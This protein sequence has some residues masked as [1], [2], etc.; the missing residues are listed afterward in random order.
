MNK[1]ENELLEVELCFNGEKKMLRGDMNKEE[2]LEILHSVS[3]IEHISIGV[4]RYLS[5]RFAKFLASHDIDV[6]RD[7]I[8]IHCIDGNV[9]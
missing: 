3:D 4:P 7:H 6:I 8:E 5:A 1:N 9:C 2:I